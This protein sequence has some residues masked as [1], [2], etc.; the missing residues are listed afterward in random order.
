MCSAAQFSCRDLNLGSAQC[1]DRAELCAC[2]QTMQ[3]QSPWASRSRPQPR[4]AATISSMTVHRP[5]WMVGLDRWYHY[6]HYQQ[7]WKCLLCEKWIPDRSHMSTKAHLNKVWYECEREEWDYNIMQQTG[8][9][10]PSRSAAS[11]ARP[12]LP[13]SDLP[14]VASQPQ[15]PLHPPPTPPA[16]PTFPAPQPPATATSSAPAGD[17]GPVAGTFAGM[18]AAPATTYIIGAGQQD[19]SWQHQDGDLLMTLQQ[20]VAQLEER[21]AMLEVMVQQGRLT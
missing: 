20:R 7:G 14:R 2:L 4:A 5:S 12:H 9:A 15:P 11:S 1:L 10:V 21:L 19:P 18:Y 13:L 16:P 6:D 8:Q 17:G 3:S